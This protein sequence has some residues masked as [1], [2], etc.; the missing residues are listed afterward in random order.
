MTTTTTRPEPS[1]LEV[2][3][4]GQCV[5]SCLLSAEG[6]RCG[7][8]K[9]GGIHHGALMRSLLRQAETSTPVNRT[10]NRRQRKADRT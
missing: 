1:A 7:C 3:K 10:A 2:L 6:T 5:P 8:K 9:C 4:T